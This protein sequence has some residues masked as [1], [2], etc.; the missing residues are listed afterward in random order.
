MDHK[1]TFINDNGQEVSGL[2]MTIKTRNGFEIVPM[3]DTVNV[4]ELIRS[5]FDSFHRDFVNEFCPTNLGC[6][7]CGC[8]GDYD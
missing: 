1:I 2:R 6:D 4:Q 7:I 5:L 8:E 3:T